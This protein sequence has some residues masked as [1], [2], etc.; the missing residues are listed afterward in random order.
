VIAGNENKYKYEYILKKEKHSTWELW[1]K[2]KRFGGDKGE[3]V[4]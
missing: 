3:Y 1:H 4:N 2:N